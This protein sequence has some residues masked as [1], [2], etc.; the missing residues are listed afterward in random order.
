MGIVNATPDSFYAHEELSADAIK[1]AR[2]MVQDGAAIIDVGGESTRP[3]FTPVDCEEEW[4]RVKNVVSTLSA[5]GIVVSID[6]RHAEVAHK[7]VAAGAQ[8]INCVEELSADMA[9]VVRVTGVKIVARHRDEKS[10]GALEEF[11]ATGQ[12]IIDPMIGFTDSREEDFALLGKVKS[13]AALSPVLVGVSRK[14]LTGGTL[15]G[16]IG[17]AVWCAINGASIVRVH[18]V[19]ETFNALKLLEDIA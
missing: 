7:A 2:Q 6:T 15:G 8:I 13:F 17:A 19:K 4:R 11:H 18:D 16:S 3:G 12:L 5:E 1:L 9:K 14:R 10:L